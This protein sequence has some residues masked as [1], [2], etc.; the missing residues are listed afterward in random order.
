MA[1][2][3]GTRG[4]AAVKCPR[5]EQ[6]HEKGFRQR[7]GSRRVRNHSQKQY[8]VRRHAGA[9]VHHG[10]AGEHGQPGGKKC[11]TSVPMKG[12]F[13]AQISHGQRISVFALCRVCGAVERQPSVVHVVCV[14]RR[15]HV[16]CRCRAGPVRG[17]R[18][19]DLSRK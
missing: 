15:F 19:G 7:A 6:T 12:L 1:A 3:C 13:S 17:R 11:D 2:K 18:A 8:R 14:R 4:P 9:I 10:L 16:A 5:L